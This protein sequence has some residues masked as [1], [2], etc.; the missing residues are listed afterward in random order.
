MFKLASW[1]VNSLKVRLEQVLEWF[2]ASASDLGSLTAKLNSDALAV[3]KSKS[4]DVEKMLGRF[5]P[6]WREQGTSS[7]DVVVDGIGWASPDNAS[8]RK[9]LLDVMVK[10]TAIARKYEPELRKV[11]SSSE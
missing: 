11:I 9:D 5:A 2:D 10:L 7:I 6:N 3:F 8:A 4:V 1:N